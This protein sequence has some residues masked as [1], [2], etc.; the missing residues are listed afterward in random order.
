MCPP[1]SCWKAYLSSPVKTLDVP[2]NTLLPFTILVLAT[3]IGAPIASRRFTCSTEFK[4]FCIKYSP[5]SVIFLPSQK[6]FT[7]FLNAGF[8]SAT[9]LFSFAIYFKSTIACEIILS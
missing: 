2:S 8:K 4:D 1:A 6:G 7:P 9:T 3:F 5:C